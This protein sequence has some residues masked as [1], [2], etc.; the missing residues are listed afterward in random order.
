M[1]DD[2]NMRLSTLFHLISHFLPL[3]NQFIYQISHKQ[4]KFCLHGLLAEFSVINHAFK[5]LNFAIE[6]VKRFLESVDPSIVHLLLACLN[7]FLPRHVLN[8]AE[9]CFSDENHPIIKG[10]QCLRSLTPEL[11]DSQRAGQELAPFH[12]DRPLL[13]G[14][15]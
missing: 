14:E 7:I 8:R 10:S 4:L 3:C 15:G 9:S 13:L 1:L 11:G 12:L 6:D 5:A 2:F